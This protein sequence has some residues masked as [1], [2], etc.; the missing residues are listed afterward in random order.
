MPVTTI[1]ISAIGQDSHRFEPA[2][3]QKPLILGGVVIPGALGL[4][5]NSDADV[6]L[7]AVTNAVSGIS[8]VNILGKISDDLCLN[9][10]ITDSRVYLEKAIETL[11]PNRWKIIHLSI[12]VEARKP[13]LSAHIP[14]IKRSVASLLSLPE[15]CVGLTATTGEGLTDFGRGEGVQVFVIASAA[16]EV[17]VAT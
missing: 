7:H 3:S 16:K 8:G 14:A 17:T 12:S 4:M 9:Q 10:G 11:V 15:S 1:S 5:G 6:I 13:H 2:G